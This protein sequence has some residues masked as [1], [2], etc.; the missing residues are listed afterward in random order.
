VISDGDHY[1]GISEA[2]NQSMRGIAGRAGLVAE[3]RTRSYVNRLGLLEN[4]R[5]RGVGRATFTLPTDIRSYDAEAC[6]GPA[7]LFTCCRR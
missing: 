7:M 3:V 1:A 4:P 5:Q 6:A 2:D